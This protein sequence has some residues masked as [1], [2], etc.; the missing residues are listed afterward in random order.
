MLKELGRINENYSVQ[1]VAYGLD[2]IISMSSTE[3]DI[4]FLL[5]A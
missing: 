4:Q 3:H 5:I 1:T 2:D